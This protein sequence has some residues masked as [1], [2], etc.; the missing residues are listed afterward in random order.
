MSARHGWLTFTGDGQPLARRLDSAVGSW[1][2]VLLGEHR[3][4]YGDSAPEQVSGAFVLQYLLQV[5]AHT[6]AVAAGLGLRCTAL[7]DLSFALGDHGE[8][9]RVEIGP[10]A[11][12][13][14]DLDQRLATAE[15]DYLA[16]TV[17]VAQAYRSTRPMSTQQR[18]GMVHDMWAEARRAVRSSAGLFTLDEPRRR[19]CCLIYALPGCVE[20]SGCPRRRR[21]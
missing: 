16:A 12:L 19:S 1:Q 7:A 11:A 8:P 3:A 6:A 5:P 14:G 21:A 15:R 4:W 10:V 18:L 17:P 13:A 20:C 9:R 2:E